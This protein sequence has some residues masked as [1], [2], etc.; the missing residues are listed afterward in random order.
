MPP[1]GVRST[2]SVAMASTTMPIDSTTTVC[3]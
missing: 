3:G 1:A 2:T